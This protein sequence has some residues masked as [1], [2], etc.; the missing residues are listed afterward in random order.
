MHLVRRAA[1]PFFAVALA[2]ASLPASSAPAPNLATKLSLREK[3][4]QLV[5][6]A[7]RGTYLSATEKALIERHHLGGLIIFSGNYSS[8]AQLDTLTRQIQRAVRAGNQ[9]RA[10][11]LISVDQEGGVVKR[12]EDMPPRY[13]APQIGASEGT[14]LAWDQGRDTGRAL[15][16]HGVNVDLAP[17]ADLDIPPQHVMRSRS[18]GSRPQ[19]VGR[20]VRSFG[21]GLQSKRTAATAK[22]FPGLGGASRNSDDG[23]AYVYRTK[24]QLHHEDVVPFRKAVNGG[25][26][27]IM[28]SH[29]IY[30]KDGGRRPASLNRYIATKRLRRELEFKGVA[31]SDAL[32]PASWWYGGDVPRTCRATIRAGVDIALITGDVYTA[33]DCA[34]QIVRGVKSGS[35]SEFRIDQA[36]RR[37]LELKT[38][39][40]L[41]P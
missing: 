3:V 2:A 33:R 4:G 34:E 7:P 39:L 24:W 23:R 31:I 41:I 32:E 30:P 6:F 15:R 35:I 21:R 20:L 8:K 27:M 26:K 9:L 18:F 38:W 40:R 10:G 29:A 1:L 16:N 22:H 28:L 19:R 25:L 17:V 13:S 11:A 36:V 5:M 12:F 14:W 37:V